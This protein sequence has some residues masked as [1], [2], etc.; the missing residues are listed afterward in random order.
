MACIT[1]AKARTVCIDVEESRPIQF[2]FTAALGG[3]TIATY[4]VDITTVAGTDPLP[5]LILDGAATLNLA[6]NIVTQW[7]HDGVNGVTYSVRCVVTTADGR[8]LVGA[9]N[10]EIVKR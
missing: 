4:D 7:I 6:K 10:I 8:E 9:I 3:D 2:D 1:C 5:E